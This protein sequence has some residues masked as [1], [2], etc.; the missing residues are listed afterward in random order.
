MLVL[1]GAPRELDAESWMGAATY[2]SSEQRLAF[3]RQ[4]DSDA[5]GSSA[6]DRRDSCTVVLSH[7]RLHRLPEVF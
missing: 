3:R 1:V 2:H 6:P 7:E 5:R 4:S